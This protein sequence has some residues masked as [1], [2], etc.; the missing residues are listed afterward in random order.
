[1]RSLKELCKKVQYYVPDEISFKVFKWDLTHTKNDFKLSWIAYIELTT[2]I[3]TNDI[4]DKYGSD[5]EALYSIFKVFKNLRKSM[6]INY[7]AKYVIFILLELMNNELRPFLNKWHTKQLNCEK[8]NDELHNNFR[9]ELKVLN[10]KIS[11]KYLVMF[12]KINNLK[13]TKF[14]NFLYKIKEND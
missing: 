3:T 14:K 11:Y 10:T 8:W 2:R 1:M 4:E 5:S 12:A 7:N 13:V 9:K 6:L